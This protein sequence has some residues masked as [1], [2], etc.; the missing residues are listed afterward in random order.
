MD[1]F[2][3]DTEKVNVLHISSYSLLNAK[4]GYNVSQ[5]KEDIYPTR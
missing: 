1:M 3:S 4:N 2:L 5:M